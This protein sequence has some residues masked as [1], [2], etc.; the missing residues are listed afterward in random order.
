MAVISNAV[1]LSVSQRE[2]AVKEEGKSSVEYEEKERRRGIKK[3]VV[4][5][6]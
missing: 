5:V 6:D 2:F 4:V 3:V 1:L